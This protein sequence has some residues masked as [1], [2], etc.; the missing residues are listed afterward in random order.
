MSLASGGDIP[1][2]AR[3]LAGGWKRQTNIMDFHTI[4][5]TP[6]I[7]DEQI[8]MLIETGE[9]TA[10]ELIDE[11]LTLFV[12]ES[13]PKIAHLQAALRERDHVA[14]AQDAH[15]I[16]GSSANLG[17]LRLAKSARV[18]E[19]SLTESTDAELM[20]LLAYLRGCYKDSIEVFR[21]LIERLGAGN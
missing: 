12:E 15:A 14:A 20:E 21:S 1:L 18:L 17:A 4:A 9:D 3:M 11:L 6:L 13:E 16:A 5:R 2:L 19:H 8:E 7:D 10:A